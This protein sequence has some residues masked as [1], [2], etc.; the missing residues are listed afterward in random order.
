MEYIGYYFYTKQKETNAPGAASH[1]NEV[2]SMEHDDTVTAT[3][4]ME[5]GTALMDDEEV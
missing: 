1:A 3:A 5:D 2:M 4:G